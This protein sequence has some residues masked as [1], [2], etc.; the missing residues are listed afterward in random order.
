[1]NETSASGFSSRPRAA[2]VACLA[3]LSLSGVGRAAASVLPGYRYDATRCENSYYFILTT[4]A[5]AR[6]E[7]P[8]R[9]EIV[10]EPAGLGVVGVLFTTCD[11]ALNG[12]PAGRASWSDVGVLIVPP[13][14]LLA[15]S[16]FF[17]VYRAW[18]VANLPAMVALNQQWGIVTGDAV[19][20][21]AF[22]PGLPITTTVGF[23]D[24]AY[25]KYGGQGY[26]QGVVHPGVEGVVTF[27]T[28]GPAGLVRFDQAYTHDREQCGVG[29]A[30][31]EGRFGALIGGSGLGVHGCVVFAD[32]TGI[33]TLVEP[34]P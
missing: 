27:W 16:P 26:F 29:A 20:E 14:G 1:M 3:L 11:V 28:L 9:F 21:T 18:G 30:T 23:V 13:G 24:S 6:A 33:A 7:V 4:A 19:V 15:E 5:R 32:L 17:H 31:G 34:A 25:G 8:A 12:A 22:A 2:A 10:G